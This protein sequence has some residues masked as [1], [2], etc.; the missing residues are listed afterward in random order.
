MSGQFIDIGIAACYNSTQVSMNA[1]FAVRGPTSEAI[2]DGLDNEYLDQALRQALREGLFSLHYEPR[3][4][5]D[6]AFTGFDALLRLS[7]PQ[8]GDLPPELFIPVAE[9]R[10]LIDPIGC[11]ALDEVCRQIGE[12]RARG[13]GEI[14]VAINVSVFQIARPDFAD[15]VRDCLER[16]NISPTAVRLK[17][18]QHELLTWIG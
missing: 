18:A 8:L 1:D 17:I 14:S 4:G 9:A 10:G 5:A 13:L 15:Q 6:G 3:L 2:D 16:R 12:W 11:W 7:H